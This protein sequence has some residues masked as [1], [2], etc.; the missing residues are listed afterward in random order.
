MCIMRHFPSLLKKE[1]VMG[2]CRIMHMKMDAAHIYYL[3]VPLWA[4][5]LKGKGI[6]A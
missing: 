5:V 2:K 4:N 3:K 1:V 6:D